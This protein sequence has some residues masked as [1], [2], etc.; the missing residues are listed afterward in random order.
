M[1]DLASQEVGMKLFS[2]MGHIR[3]Q[4]RAATITRVI[5][6]LT[7]G[8]LGQKAVIVLG[9]ALVFIGV[10]KVIVQTIIPLVAIIAGW[11]LVWL[12]L[13]DYERRLMNR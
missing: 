1:W 2:S 5:A 13:K 11:T 6:T 12:A 10:Y 7:G 8:S 3:D 4:I 9:L